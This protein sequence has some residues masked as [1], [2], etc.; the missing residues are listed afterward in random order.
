MIEKVRTRGNIRNKKIDASLAETMKDTSRPAQKEERF[1]NIN[2]TEMSKDTIGTIR[3]M[4]IGS[5]YLKIVVRLAFKFQSML[6]NTDDP[7]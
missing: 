3:N 6:T 7:I 1:A 4:P 2:I 5:F